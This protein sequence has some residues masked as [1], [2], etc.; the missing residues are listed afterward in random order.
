MLT[1][2]QINISTLLSF[3]LNVVIIVLQSKSFQTWITMYP[4]Y[5]RKLS[6]RFIL[7]PYLIT[8]KESGGNQLHKNLVSDSY[9]FS[10]VQFSSVSQLCLTLCDPMNPSTPGLPV[11]QQLPEF[12]RFTSIQSVMPSSHLILCRALLLCPQS[13]PASESFPMSQLFT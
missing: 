9:S 8:G 13:L 4:K 6:K 7:E 11:H 1:F 2:L 5:L 10:S 3:K 12:T